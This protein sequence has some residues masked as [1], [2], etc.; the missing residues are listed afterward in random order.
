MS[1]VTV[2]KPNRLKMFKNNVPYYTGPVF[3]LDEEQ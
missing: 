1:N 3:K 2:D